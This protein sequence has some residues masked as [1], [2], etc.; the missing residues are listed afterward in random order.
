MVR[1]PALSRA[2]RIARITLA[3]RPAPAHSWRA[4]DRPVLGAG[5]CASRS[6]PATRRAGASQ[7]PSR[8]APCR[9]RPAR[10]SRRQAGAPSS[11]PGEAVLPRGHPAGVHSPPLPP[12]ASHSPPIPGCLTRWRAPAG[13]RPAASG[14]TVANRK[15]QREKGGRGSGHPPRAARRSDYAARRRGAHHSRRRVPPPEGWTVRAS[16]Q[17][18]ARITLRTNARSHHGR[19]AAASSH[20]GARQQAAKNA[21]R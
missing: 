4:A 2:V 9:L 1:P 19:F 11:P 6:A 20:P 12:S 10:P 13:L 14:Q 8:P 5:G 15:A 21:A 17:R 18:F 7:A 16:S 3:A